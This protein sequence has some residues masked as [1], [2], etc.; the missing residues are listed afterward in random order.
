V[1]AEPT[2]ETAVRRLA[3]DTLVVFL[4]DVHIGGADGTEI[5]ESVT[6]LTAL[7][8]EI[9][10]HAGPVELVLLGD[11]LD[12]QRMGPTGQVNDRVVETLS[13]R[14]YAELFNAQRRFRSTA[15]HHVTY[16]MG[17]HDAEM[18]WNAELQQVLRDAGLIDEFALSY[19]ARFEAPGDQVIHSE[20]GNQFDPTNRFTDYGDPLDTPIG[21]HVVDDIVRPIGSSA[22]LTGNLD[23]RDVSYVYSIAAI[24]EWIAGR[25]FYRFLGEALRWILILFVIANLI[26]AA[27][28]WLGSPD[29]LRS[30]TRAV[31]GELAYDVGV[32]FL[33]FVI[34][35]L[36]GR[37]MARRARTALELR[38]TGASAG[39][40][41][42]GIRSV[43][44]AHEPLPM[45]S[46][47][48]PADIAVFVSGHTHS[49]SS[50]NLVRAD[51]TTTAIVNTGCWLRQ[52]QPVKARFGAPHVFVP[53]FIQTHARVRRSDEGVAVEVWRCPKPAPMSLPWIEPPSHPRTVTQGSQ[54][55]RGAARNRTTV[56][57]K[58]QGCVNLTANRPRDVHAGRSPGR[59]RTQSY[60]G[61]AGAEPFQCAPESRKQRPAMGGGYLPVS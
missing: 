44:L 60:R 28:V 36:A 1:T 18:W 22:R 12:L 41:P 48:D 45:A 54:P 16:V 56:D 57:R 46:E 34:V 20:H 32:L 42:E 47:V 30:T 4:S 58:S 29:A 53:V 3:D 61:P 13:R 31:L 19:T 38:L 51:G 35:F 21:S 26:H 37:R 50:S 14:D 8:Q 10:Q 59:V 15:G 23:L 33:V 40:E 52:L 11:F 17:N 5:F 24:P 7:F 39:S 2:R 25:I 6:E 55:R 27:L 43:L 49:P 9:G